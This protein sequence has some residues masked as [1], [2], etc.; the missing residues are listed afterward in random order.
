M[1]SPANNLS[2]PVIIICW[3]FLGFT[4]PI[5][6]TSSVNPK[7]PT[8]KIWHRP[9][10]TI[11]ESND[12]TFHSCHVHIKCFSEKS[13]WM[14]DNL[15]R[16]L[17][18]FIDMNKVRTIYDSENQSILNPTT[19]RCSLHYFLRSPKTMAFEIADYMAYTIPKFVGRR[20]SQT[21]I[22][23]VMEL[24][25]LNIVGE[26][27]SRRIQWMDGHYFFLNVRTGWLYFRN[28][29]GYWNDWV[30]SQDI[31]ALIASKMEDKWDKIGNTAMLGVRTGDIEFLSRPGNYPKRCS[32]LRSSHNKRALLCNL[33]TVMAEV[34]ADVRNFTTVYTNDFSNNV[35]RTG[36]IVRISF[37]EFDPD[38]TLTDLKN[39]GAGRIIQLNEVV[40]P[41]FVYCTDNLRSRSMSLSVWFNPFD[42]PSWICIIIL[43]WLYWV[44]QIISSGRPYTFH[45]LSESILIIFQV[46]F[47]QSL[48][49]P[50]KLSMLLVAFFLISSFIYE[51]FITSS[52]IAPLK[53]NPFANISEAM[54][55]GYVLTVGI[56]NER[57]YNFQGED[58]FFKRYEHA[59]H[60]YGLFEKLT[61]TR[62]HHRSIKSPF[63]YISGKPQDYINVIDKYLFP[64][65]DKYIYYLHMGSY[66]NQFYRMIS[67]VKY[68]YKCLQTKEG[69]GT[70]ST[71]LTARSGI[72]GHL[73]P[74]F[75]GIY[76]AGLT[77]P[78]HHLF[79]HIRETHIGMIWNEL[80]KFK[81]NEASDLEEQLLTLSNIASLFI[82]STVACI[83]ASLILLVEFKGKGWRYSI[84]VFITLTYFRLIRLGYLFQSGVSLLMGFVE[85]QWVHMLFYC[86]DRIRRIS[87]RN[88]INP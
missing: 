51:N 2:H 16:S 79:I 38:E 9:T 46:M 6:S 71:F 7:E 52:L 1:A 13:L 37:G 82:A 87:T 26:P 49:K 54:N 47:R 10:S 86:S 72:K 68:P 60:R 76:E 44:F 63:L 40:S 14:T 39:D 31:G 74:V 75:R 81:R 12:R 48:S 23:H 21:A 22:I 18:H 88:S 33:L 19:E 84:T 64:D 5:I 29:R 45:V 59:L 3:F 83:F 11:Q 34:A 17:N 67:E 4:I 78:F 53:E 65:N 42:F 36:E 41:A 61:R 24:S 50:K 55:S 77:V 66:S 25:P 15:D 69:L 73:A 27:H 30:R 70:F 58:E 28:V 43:L 57:E 20:M 8:L 80:R 35:Y 56:V 85:S 62:S 32:S